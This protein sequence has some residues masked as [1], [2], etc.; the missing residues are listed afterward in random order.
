VS[1]SGE[2]FVRENVISSFT[3]MWLSSFVLIIAGV[4][5]TYQATNDSAI[6]NIDT[7]FNWLRS[8]LGL[9]K[10]SILEK[11]EHLAGKFDYIEL[12]RAD[13]KTEFQMLR[14]YAKECS[15]NLNENSGFK[16][17]VNQAYNNCNYSFLLEFKIHYYAFIDRIMPSLWYRIPYFKKR[18]G[19]FPDV[20]FYTSRNYYKSSVFRKISLFVFP[21]FLFRL[22]QFYIDRRN[23]KQNLILITGLSSGMINLLNSSAIKTDLDEDN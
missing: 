4:F 9:K 10:K 15:E 1:L 3:G 5:L 2:K 21:L 22:L 8:I 7:Y 18:L 11:K 6:L 19:E 17:L 14:D 23:I 20:N 12:N 16:K 13:I